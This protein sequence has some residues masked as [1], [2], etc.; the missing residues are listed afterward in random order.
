MGHDTNPNDKLRARLAKLL[1]LAQRG[2]GGEKDN[3]Q[4]MLEK[5]LAKHGMTL[6]D[7]LDDGEKKADL[8]IPFK[9][10]ED[11]KLVFQV[12]AAVL[13]THKPKVYRYKGDRAVLVEVTP[14]QRADILVRLDAY[15]KPLAAAINK[16]K[17]TALAAFIQVNRV[18]PASDDPE[19]GEPD[20][21]AADE[22]AALL[23]AMRGMQPTPVHQQLT[24]KEAA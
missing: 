18:F 17:A 7:L 13:D 1:A 5:L 6:A 9:G 16:A 21:L 24:H 2:V 19:S 14:A 3:A 15:R 23:A 20:E 11:R 8:R 12:I 4:R 22:L 10:V